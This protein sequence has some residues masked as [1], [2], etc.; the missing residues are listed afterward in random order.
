MHLPSCQRRCLES[1][2]PRH[3]AMLTTER[4]SAMHRNPTTANGVMMNLNLDDF[5]A[6]RETGLLLIRG[7]PLDL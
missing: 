5:D 4:G 7:N 6:R 3:H 2:L 1:D